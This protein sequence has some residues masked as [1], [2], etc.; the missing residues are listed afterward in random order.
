VLI[1]VAAILFYTSAEKLLTFSISPQQTGR[2][3][4]CSNTK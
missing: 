2:R 3:L 4:I 1:N